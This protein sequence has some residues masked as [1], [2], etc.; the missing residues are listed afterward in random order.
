MDRVQAKKAVAPFW[1]F[2]ALVAVALGCAPNARADK[3]SDRAGWMREARFGVMTHFL[4][5]WITREQRDPMTPENWNRLV[6]GF[7]VEAVA[8][9]L[10]SVGAAWYLISIGQNSGYY[11]SPNATY[12]RVTGIAPSKL[13]RRDLIA[14]LGL[15]LS[16]R[17]IKLMVYLPSG[18]PAGDAAART[19]LQWQNGPNRNAEFQKKWEAIIREWSLRWG[20]KVAGW[21]FDGV[22]WPNN[23][24]RGAKPP[25]FRSFAEAARAGNPHSAVA[26][27]PGQVNRTLSL[28][29]YEDY[30]AGEVGDPA[31]WST[32]RNFDGWID[33]AQIHFLSH[34]GAQWGLGTPR[35]T[36]EQAIAFS[37]KIAEVGGV[38]TW[39]TPAK[40]N[41]TFAPEFLAQLKAIG[42]AVR[43]TP[44]KPDSGPGMRPATPPE[45]SPNNL[46]TAVAGA[47][48]LASTRG[49]ARLDAPVLGSLPGLG[50]AQHDFICA[51]QWDT[52]NPLETV[53]LV[54]GGKVVWTFTIPDKNERNETAEFSDIH[55]L[56][57]GNLLYAHKTGAAEVTADKKLVWSYI[58][59]P[60]TEVHS[61]QPIGND[62]V[63]LGQNGFPAKALLINKRTGRI[64]M[65]H[66]LETQPKPEDPALVGGSI[67]GQFR[68]IR[69]TKGGT[70]LIA[71]LNLGKVREYDRNW[72]QIFE[73]DAP[74]AWTA[75]RLPNGNTLI[76]GNQ[77]GYVREV[78]AKGATV[79]EINKDDLPGIPLYTVQEVSRLN[80]GNTIISNWGGSIQKSDWEKVVQYIEVSPDKKVVWALH[81]WKDPDLGPGSLM[82]ILDEGGR[83]E[84]FEQLR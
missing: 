58:A 52:R 27:N 46:T 6:D 28:T 61:A 18:A 43:A 8:D 16:R 34:L 70:Y 74:S 63:F 39:D 24:Y 9:Q 40:R 41:G 26:F 20:D 13:S 80:N 82:Q 37:R 38:V 72:K 21:W 78:N 7:D 75:V 79:W 42:E 60:G 49:V 15:A 77:H 51:G 33:G 5:D 55:L 54:R 47:S 65:E 64:E 84:E 73:V 14:D 56:S 76:G 69:M 81:Q 31:L 48:Q 36:T 12:D 50:L 66:E 44:I 32:A 59:P 71:H 30:I 2:L 19:A 25:N 3:N 68:H 35:F 23:M 57:N 29:P 22:Y 11:L 17:G 45:D 62:R 83:A 10:Q 53:T 4:H 1:L 67:H